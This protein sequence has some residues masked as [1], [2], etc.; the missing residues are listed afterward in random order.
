MLNPTSLVTLILAL[1]LTTAG[2]VLGYSL[3]HGIGYEQGKAAGA[4]AEAAALNAQGVALAQDAEA[5]RAAALQPG[6]FARLRA[7][8][9]TNCP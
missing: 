3:G 5:A 4:A 1:V 9:C 6:A 8:W 7:N 2:A